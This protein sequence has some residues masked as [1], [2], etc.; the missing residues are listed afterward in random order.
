MVTKQ[1]I[2]F[3]E[4]INLSNKNMEQILYEFRYISY[5]THN[6]LIILYKLYKN[7]A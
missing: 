1:Y 4:S 6:N 3:R 2:N 7:N 5:L